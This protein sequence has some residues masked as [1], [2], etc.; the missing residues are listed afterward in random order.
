MAL[1]HAYGAFK[2]IGL[3]VSLAAGFVFAMDP[4]VKV[5]LIAGA[6]VV[7]A[8]LPALIVGLLNRQAVQQM[9]INVD[10]NL[11]RLL[12]EK[13]EQVAQLKD[14]GQKLAR[15]EGVKQGSDEERDRV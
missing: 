9:S 7:L 14:Q 3:G 10:G 2:V 15:A 1:P 6:A 13:A 4:T 12:D 11:Q 5:A 8:S